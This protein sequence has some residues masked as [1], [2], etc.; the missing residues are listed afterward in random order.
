MSVAALVVLGAAAATA[1]RARRFYVEVLCRGFARA[2]L[3]LLGVRLV[4]H[5]DRPWPVT[6]TVYIS[7]H[8]SGLDVFVLLAL[9]LPN[10]RFFLSGFFLSGFLRAIVPMG[11][12]GQLAGTFWTVPQIYPRRRVRVFQRADRILRRTGESVYLSPEGMRVQTGEM[13]A[14]NKGA[15][16]LAG[17]L[18]APLLPLY[19]AVPL[20]EHLYPT[21]TDRPSDYTVRTNLKSFLMDFR[22]CEVHVYV[23]SPIDTSAWRLEDLDRNRQMVRQR[24]LAMHK[25]WK[26][27]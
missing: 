20:P 12:I 24:F 11:I 7:N 1:F 3:R 2:L 15:F 27:A 23:D 8:T 4:V 6:Q 17:S 5:N 10:T 18:G 25:R 16:H 13:G 9:A 21:G 22:P 14:F 26:A 19:L